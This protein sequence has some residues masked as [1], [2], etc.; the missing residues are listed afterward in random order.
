MSPDNLRKF[1][2]LC[3][4]YRHT[5]VEKFVLVNERYQELVDFVNLLVGDERERIIRA[6][7]AG[8]RAGEEYRASTATQ[9]PKEHQ[10][11]PTPLYD[12]GGIRVTPGGGTNWVTSEKAQQAD[13]SAC[14]DAP[15]KYCSVCGLRAHEDSGKDGR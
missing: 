1:Y 3:Q 7:I 9:E 13:C 12:H 10:E 4:A 15:K 14:N 2:E 5:P 6:T 11:Q 8:M